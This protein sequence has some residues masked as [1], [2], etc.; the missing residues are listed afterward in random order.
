MADEKKSEEKEVMVEVSKNQLDELL[1]RVSSIEENAGNDGIT[2]PLS[3]EDVVKERTIRL[4]EID[5]KIVTGLKKDKYEKVIFEN[6][7]NEKGEKDMTV[8]VELLGEDG[9]KEEKKMFYL[10]DLLHEA[11]EITVPVIDT[12]SEKVVK[13]HGTVE[14]TS[15]PDG[16][17]TSK[18][19]GVQVY[20]EDVSWKLFSTV[21]LPDGREIE[22]SNEFINMR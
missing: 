5:N 19:S 11:H 2:K 15:V 16:G 20:L 9:K 18:G 1:K 3:L 21:T 4:F 13:K 12:R 10:M 7:K 6:L 22:V 8:I 17:W 14:R